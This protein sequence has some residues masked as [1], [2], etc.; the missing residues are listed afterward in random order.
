[1]PPSSRHRP[2]ATAS[3]SANEPTDQGEN[4]EHWERVIVP[5]DLVGER[6]DRALVALRPELSRTRAQAAIK[7]GDVLV[8]GKSAKAS[9]ALET[10]WQLALSP[11][12]GEDSSASWTEGQ[13]PQPEAN[14]PLRVVYEDDHLLVVDKPA[15]IVVHPA[16]GHVS[17][18]L[19]NA[20]LAH[21]PDLEGGDNP[22]RPGIVHRLDKDTSGLMVIAKD[23]PTHAALA[24]QMQQRSMIKRY[25][26]LVEGHL[27]QREGVIEAPIGRDTRHRQR[28]AV[29]SEARG[30]RPSRTRFRVV[31]EGRGRSLLDVQLDTGRTHQIRVH[32]QAIHH[33]VVGDP[34]YGR[35]QQPLPPRQFLHAAHLAFAH[36]IT[37]EWLTFDAPLPEDLA[38]FLAE[39]EG[40]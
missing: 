18:T 9:L 34:V 19:V 39:W 38:A 7:A 22:A 2:D 8:N 25:L 37:G 3:L 40:Q 30:G 26:A 16:P 24:E 23:A 11:T 36:P 13:T 14:I 17:G 35:L 29:V 6:L 12:L 31:R 21:A 20:L 33:P 27:D 5:D 1:M 15:G 10:G 32:M 4:S 28:M